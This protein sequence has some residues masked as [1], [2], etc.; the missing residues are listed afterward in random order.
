MRRP[1]R[2]QPARAAAQSV[3]LLA[4]NS[5]G[6]LPGALRL[7]GLQGLPKGAGACAAHRADVRQEPARRRR[8]RVCSNSNHGWPF[9]VVRLCILSARFDGT[10][11]PRRTGWAR[12]LR[13]SAARCVL[14]LVSMLNACACTT[15][16]GGCGPA[17]PSDTSESAQSLRRSGGLPYTSAAPAK[18]GHGFDSPTTRRNSRAGYPN[19][20]FCCAVRFAFY[21]R[22]CGEGRE[23]LPVPCSG[24][25][26]PHV[27]SPSF[28]SEG[29]RFQTC[30][31]GAIH[32]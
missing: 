8:H 22:A 28:D 17:T 16:G 24:L 25:S 30:Q 2:L 32:G 18:Q 19:A 7:A 10:G 21:G 26:T 13:P 3:G 27:L 14:A 31:Q 9:V 4:G 20:A 1:A 29:G 5:H 23:S 6:G 15:S 12:R 11:T